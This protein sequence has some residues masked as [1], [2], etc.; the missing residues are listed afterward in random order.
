M[1]VASESEECYQR[2]AR[3]L[4]SRFRRANAPAPK[5]LYTDNNCCR[6]VIAALQVAAGG[7]VLWLLDE[8]K[9]TGAKVAE[10][11]PAGA[12]GGIPSIMVHIHKREKVSH[13]L[14]Y[15]NFTLYPSLFSFGTLL[16]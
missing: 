16:Q 7:Y 12:C 5:V 15:R 1:F 6:L 8:F 4:S 2:M 9:A 10:G 13:E 14:C 11:A 3:G